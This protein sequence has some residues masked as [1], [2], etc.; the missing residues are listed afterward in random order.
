MFPSTPLSS[1]FFTPT[2]SPYSPASPNKLAVAGAGHSL[3]K[4]SASSGRAT[5]G[6]AV[7]VDGPGGVGIGA[8]A[9][10]AGASASVSRW[11]SLGDFKIPARI[12]QAQVGLQQNLGR[13]RGFAMGV[14]C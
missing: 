7:G 13:V 3:G 2:G 8:S 5:A 9:G 1:I 4:Q 6:G 10:S 12:R 14:E 11:N